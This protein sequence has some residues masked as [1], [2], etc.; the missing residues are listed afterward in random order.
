MSTITDGTSN[1]MMVGENCGKMYNGNGT[2]LPVPGDS[3]NYDGRVDNNRGFH[4][5]TS[6]IGY[7]DGD[8]SMFSGG[9]PIAKGE[10]GT[11][12]SAPLPL[13]IEKTEILFDPVF[14]T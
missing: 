3:Y 14:I 4:M 8:N 13:S 6:H 2:A 7:P 9:A 11:S 1:T 12:A 10:L 5:G